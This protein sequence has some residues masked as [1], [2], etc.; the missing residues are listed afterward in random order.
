MTS[1]LR[2]E[3]RALLQEQPPEKFAPAETYSF[4]LVLVKLPPEAGRRVLNAICR[5]CFLSEGEAERVKFRPLPIEL[6]RGMCYAD[7]AIGQF[8]IL[9]CDALAFIIPDRVI[10]D[11]P[12]GYLADLYKTLAASS[13]F[14]TVDVAIT[15]L[16]TSP[17]AREF[18]DLF[19]GDPAADILIPR[20]VMRRKAW[21]MKVLAERI[22]GHVRIN[23]VPYS[24]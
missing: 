23:N 13:D 3:T 7:A 18:L 17:K 10:D 8:E 15:S 22:G 21:L 20:R 12:P 16:P 24:E 5:A 11:P 4:T 19:V 2:A 14:E 6:K 1:W 9:A